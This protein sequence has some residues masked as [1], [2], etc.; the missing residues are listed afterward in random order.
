MYAAASQQPKTQKGT[1]ILANLASEQTS[2]LH[3]R[4]LLLTDSCQ[5]S[6][7]GLARRF[8]DVEKMTGNFGM[9]CPTGS[10]RSKMRIGI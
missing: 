7:N 10:N 8:N 3:A 6:G 2:T 4:I 9:G 5:V 1:E